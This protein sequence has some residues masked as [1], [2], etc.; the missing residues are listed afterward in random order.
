MA[1]VDFTNPEACEWWRGNLAKNIRIG[2]DSFKT[3]FGER[4]PI[5]NVRWHD[6]SD[7]AR[8]HNYF[9][10]LYNKNV[11]ETLEEHRGKSN[12][13]VWARS[14]TAGGQ[15][16][17]VH[18][19]GDPES[20]FDAMAESI[21]GALSLGICGFG[22]HSADI[23]GFEGTPT[24]TLYKRWVQFGLLQSHTRLHG[25]GSYRVPWLYDGEDSAEA[26]SGTKG[27][28]NKTPGEASRILKEAVDRKIA[29]MP[30]LLSQALQAAQHGT[31]MM[32][33]LFL[34]FP[35]DLNTY[36][37]EHQYMLGCNLLVAPVLA[38]SG[39]VTFY[40]PED[41]N[42]GKWVSW[43]DHSKKYAGGK[44]YTETF[45]ISELPLLVRPGTVTPINRSLKKADD[46]S[47]EG[48][49]LL[50]CGKL[51]GEVVLELA[52][53]E[54]THEVKRKITVKADGD[55]VQAVDAGLKVKISY[56]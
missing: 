21:R 32:R 55:K 9:S 43:F 40:V 39:T 48:L 11:Y 10:L 33:A 18:W 1:I 34:E 30:Y 12:S 22:F 19:G 36:A 41:P 54:K 6:G 13:L 4:I 5:R 17:P 28:V 25:N 15:V 42:G 7:P 2:V 16:Y 14:T 20:T 35:A 45:G 46:A 8:M 37:I 47:E 52:D 38:E 50:V 51:D 24:P 3:D 44:W 27:D 26:L 23:G 56:M 53:V 49:E 29:M 31:P